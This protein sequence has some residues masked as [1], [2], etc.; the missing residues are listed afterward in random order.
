MHIVA[1]Y[2]STVT[3][4]NNQFLYVNGE[5]VSAIN[6]PAILKDDSGEVR[7]GQNSDLTMKNMIH[8][9]WNS[10]AIFN[11]ALAQSE[12]QTRYQSTN[13]GVK[14][15][16]VKNWKIP[17]DDKKWQIGGNSATGNQAGYDQMGGIQETFNQ[18][19]SKSQSCLQTSDGTRFSIQGNAAQRALGAWKYSL[20][21]EYDLSNYNYC[22]IRYRA[23]KLQRSVK[24]LAVISLLDSQNTTLLNSSEIILDGKWHWL[25]KKI[26]P[27]GASSGIK[28]E[29]STEGS[30]AFAELSHVEF[31][32]TMPAIPI[33]WYNDT[34]AKNDNQIKPITLQN[35]NMGLNDLYNKIIDDKT[36]AVTDG[37]EGFTTQD[38]L[39]SG[40]AFNVHPKGA[41]LIFDIGK[42]EIN[43]QK[44]EVFGEQVARKSFFP[45]G[46]DTQINV[47][48]NA[49][50]SEVFLLLVTDFPAWY[51]PYAI[52]SRPFHLSDI[53]DF[54]V[55]IVYADGK[56][57]LAFPYSIRN[58]GYQIEGLLGAYAIP[59]DSGKTLDKLILHNKTWAGTVG[60]MAASANFSAQRILPELVTEPKLLTTPKPEVIKPIPAKI[61]QSGKKLT[62]EN[63]F[64]SLVLDC[65]DTFIISQIKNLTAPDSPINLDKTS[66]IEVIANGKSYCGQDFDVT[67][68]TI[69]DNV[70]TLDL[71]SKNLTALP[72][73]L[74]IELTADAS[75]ALAINMNARNLGKT[76][77]SSDIRF[78]V[79]K[80]LTIGN[81]EDTWYFFP[82]YRNVLGNT[83]VFCKQPNH[84]GFL[85]QFF[86]IFN[87]KTGSGITLQS[88]NLEQNP[89]V[90]ALSKSSQGVNAYIEE[91]GYDNI[92]PANQSLALI[93][94]VL[95]IHGGDWRT[96]AD[97]YQKWVKSWYKPLNSQDKPFFRKA[98]W[99]RAHI[100]SPKISSSINQTPPLIDVSS[101]KYRIEEVLKLDKEY[102]GVDPDIFH[103]FCWA[104]MPNQEYRN[105]QRDGEY[106]TQDYNNLGG[107]E[108]FRSAI[109]LL[110]NKFHIPVSL[111]TIC[112][113]YSTDTEFYK[114]YG[115]SF[116]RT[117]STGKK[118]VTA[119]TIYTSTAFAVWREYF[120]STIKRLQAD[121]GAKVIYIDLLATSDSS[122][123]YSPN[124]GLPVPSQVA[125][126]DTLF[127]KAIREGVP[128]TALWGEFPIPDVG[129]QYWDGF[130]SY[131]FTPLNEYIAKTYD[132]LEVAP[133]YGA[134][135]AN[136][137][138]FLFPGLR[139]FGFPC[140]EIDA[141]RSLK[142][143]LFNGQG[144][145]EIT[146]R[147]YYPETRKNM[148]RMLTIQKTCSDCFSS[149]IPEMW[150]PVL[151]ANVYAN[152][153][154]GEKRTIW[155]IYNSRYQ[156]IT[157]EVIAVPHQAGS[158]YYDLWNEREITPTIRGNQA[159]I[160]LD[161]PPQSIGC[162]VQYQKN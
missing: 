42:P 111:Y 106:S 84:R 116:A 156:E 140:G 105:S 45:A 23:G 158:K 55:E 76:P 125:K 58:Q 139:Q 134:L 154:P 72:L 136:L 147:L 120:A 135:P 16:T 159:I 54:S 38:I 85:M 146:W 20:G 35:F 129:S 81:D 36:K 60:L 71:R 70:I 124:Q 27:K 64:Y 25:I 131:D 5:L 6:N 128:D 137:F 57:S 21:E 107:L 98:A 83:P 144:I 157:G 44:V 34:P 53:E 150:V 40:I 142:F 88:R 93:P 80:N 51:T 14:K 145:D 22:L 149:N 67:N 31:S 56:K 162:I 52:S 69:K 68:T 11:H 152:K 18:S 7:I 12:V 108:S 102:L 92:I 39:I 130:I 50:V 41:N 48:V 8:A 114:K 66:G 138:R 86:D 29:I 112:D 73:G 113:R 46:R 115:D 89:V 79:L 62:I 119:T 94:R 49:K 61:S 103:F 15:M 63:S 101:G 99:M 109:E 59:V 1:T 141:W 30:E 65:N 148:T 123:S 4:G 96:A 47:P 19:L 75:N 118:I 104:Y 151:R 143:L 126:S 90:Y 33:A 10:V 13:P 43:S 87:P 26:E 155:T 37:V 17:L 82:Q 127:L 133:K 28:L 97:I 74:T 153:F 95:A 100:V 78:P 117:T 77:L 32:E 132:E 110:Q 161:M 24:P 160:S 3:D 121:T 9:Q 2:D 122:K 91:R